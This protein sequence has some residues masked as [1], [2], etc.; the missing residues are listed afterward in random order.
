[1][2]GHFD[3]QRERAVVEFHH[4]TLEGLLR[5]VNRDFKQLQN[6]RL[7]LAEHFARGNA[8]QQRVTNLTSSTGNCN[9]DGFF[10]HD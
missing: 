3:E 7:V 1:M 6:N 2:R 9:A 4:H 10:V 5:A 8:K